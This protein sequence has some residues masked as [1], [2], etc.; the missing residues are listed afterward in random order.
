MKA[1]CT[2]VAVDLVLLWDISQQRPSII[3][4]RLFVFALLEGHVAQI[5]GLLGGKGHHVWC[6]VS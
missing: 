5:L 6:A 1:E 4:Q 3:L 2:A